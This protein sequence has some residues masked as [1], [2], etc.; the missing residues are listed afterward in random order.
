MIIEIYTRGTC[1]YSA[2]VKRLLQKRQ[3]PYKE[4][5]M[6][7]GLAQEMM[8]RTGQSTTPIVFLD[9]NHIGGFDELVELD[10]DGKL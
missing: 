3:Q 6:S 10:Q 5:E 7:D 4:I 8:E 9:G 2:A 1:Q